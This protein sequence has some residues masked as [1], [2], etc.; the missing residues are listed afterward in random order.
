MTM[1]LI[2]TEDDM[3]NLPPC[4]WEGEGRKTWL[5]V[6]I[7]VPADEERV[8]LAQLKARDEFYD[9]IGKIVDN[10]DAEIGGDASGQKRLCCIVPDN[11]YGLAQQWVAKLKELGL[12]TK[13]TVA[14][15]QY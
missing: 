11:S 12:R 8:T 1:T 13:I 10:I 9:R 6:Q 5:E 2:V 15:S 7:A 4:D 14:T 3:K